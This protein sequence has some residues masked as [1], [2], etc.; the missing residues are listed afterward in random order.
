MMAFPPAMRTLLITISF[1]LFSS[2]ALSWEI[3][4]S[5]VGDLVLGEK[6]SPS[7]VRSGK[8]KVD[9]LI[10]DG[11]PFKGFIFKE[12]QLMVSL[13]RRKVSMIIIDSPAIMTK[14]RIGVGSTFKQIEVV[15]KNARLH[16]VPP[17]LGDDEAV[18]IIPDLSDVYFYF[19]D[20]ES[21]RTGGKVTRIMIFRQ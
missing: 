21:A 1:L 19:K 20:L 2:T 18:A 4:D 14:E 7:F 13:E 9:R 11:V 16:A 15:Y 3:H 12:P 10:C 17:C 8:E 6:L 5:G